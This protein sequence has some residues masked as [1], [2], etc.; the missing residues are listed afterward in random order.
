M[1]Q[2]ADGAASHTPQPSGAVILGVERSVTGRRWVARACDDRIAVAL[3]QRLG[4]PEVLG[5]VLAARGVGL[6]EAEAYLNPTVRDALPDPSTFRDIDTAAQRLSKAVR[7]GEP[8]AIFGDYDVDGA[9]SSAL[10]ARFFGAVGGEVRTYIPDR[11]I[12]GYGP[13]A[14][15]LLGLAA[16]G[17]K[18]VVTV[19]CGTTAFEALDAAA[20]AGLDVIVVD[21]HV[22]EADLPTSLAVINPNRMDENNPHGSLAAVGVAFLLAVAVNRVLRQ[23]GWYGPSRPE[24]DL[25]GWLDLVALGTICDV[26]PLVG[27]N[28]ALVIQG[29][30]VMAERRN[31]GLTAL[32]DVAGLAEPPG[33]YHAGFVLGPR[34]NAG[35]R[36]GR[37]DLGTRL[38]TTNDPGEA[39]I[40]AE[41]LD[42]HNAERKAIEAGVLAAAQDQVEAAGDPGPLVFVAAKDWHPGV[43]GI[44]AARLKEQWRRPAIVIGLADGVGKGS[45]RSVPGVDLG[46]AVISARQAGFLINGG[47]HPMA[48]GLTVAADQIEALGRFLADR[49]GP[50]LAQTD[51][52]RDL[53][54]D[55]TLAPGA[56]TADLVAKLEL[57]GPYGSGNPEPRFAVGGAR[58]IRA[59]VVGQGHVRMI[60]GGGDGGRLKAIAFRA[61]DG[62]LGKALLTARETPIHLAG[63]LRADNWQG[64]KGAQLVIQDAAKGITGE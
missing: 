42:R 16:E 63:N 50:Q 61:A 35:G 14:P 32:A 21:H 51:A 48:A 17:V 57:G 37:A 11:I 2:L 10:L 45:G 44:V 3:A 58:V 22:A 55:G 60:L 34:V 19:D 25:L 39:R 38:L 6:D 53:R 26:V 43:I 24:P 59:D 18:V 9:T 52:A 4:L 1:S 62:P 28:R 15:A 12:E 64:R 27:L 46:A 36:V 13:N 33:A 29:L 40:L 7:D 47:G 23:A 54:L 49:I 20:G 5:R 41:E 31:V 8:I 30:K 56:A